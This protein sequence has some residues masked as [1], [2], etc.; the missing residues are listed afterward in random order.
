MTAAWRAFCRWEQLISLPG[1]VARRDQNSLRRWRDC[2]SWRDNEVV[3]NKSGID[4]AHVAVS[5]RLAVRLLTAYNSGE[6]SKVMAIACGPGG[7]REDV[8]GGKIA[9]T[10]TIEK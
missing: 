4:C 5:L 2:Y 6:T 7:S 1:I 3:G 9:D 8:I 10:A